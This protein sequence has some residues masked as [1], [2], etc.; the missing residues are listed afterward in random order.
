MTI[1]P[2]KNYQTRDGWDVRIY[3]I[4]GQEPYPIHGAVLMKFTR[5]WAPYQWT[6]D[7]RYD[8]RQK[9]NPRDLLEI[10]VG[11]P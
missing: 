9:S 7:G 10:P 11:S 6:R 4:D 8:H 3:A 1:D 2:G 5:E